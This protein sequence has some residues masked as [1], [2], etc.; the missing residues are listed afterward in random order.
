MQTDIHKALHLF[1]IKRNCCILR[2]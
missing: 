1:Y 2:Q